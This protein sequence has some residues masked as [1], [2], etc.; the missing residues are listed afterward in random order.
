MVVKNSVSAKS[1]DFRSKQVNDLKGYERIHTGKKPFECNTCGKC[2][3]RPRNL[4]SHLTMHSGK[5]D[6]INK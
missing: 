6:K 4:N 2:F 1:V 3:K 5:K